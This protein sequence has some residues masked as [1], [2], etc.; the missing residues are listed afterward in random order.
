MINRIVSVEKNANRGHLVQ[1][2]GDSSQP[3]A[4]LKQGR[5]TQNVDHVIGERWGFAYLKKGLRF[6]RFLVF[7]CCFLAPWFR[8]HFMFSKDIW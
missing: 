1:D 7:A 3:G 4:P 8:D 2:T 5:R 6:I